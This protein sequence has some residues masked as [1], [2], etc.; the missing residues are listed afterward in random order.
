MQPTS[1]ENN[2]V[3]LHCN[4]AARTKTL[5]DKMR[6]DGAPQRV[7]KTATELTCDACE[8][9]KPHE[10][11]N[12]AYGTKLWS[13]VELC[14]MDLTVG[15]TQHSCKGL[16]GGGGGFAAGS[17]VSDGEH[18]NATA[19]ETTSL[20]ENSYPAHYPRLVA[21]RFD[22]EGCSVSR[23][24]SDTLTR[25]D[26]SPYPTAGQAHPSNLGTWERTIQ[27]LKRSAETLDEIHPQH[28]AEEVMSLV[29]SIRDELDR[30]KGYCPFQWTF[31]DSRRVWNTEATD[32]TDPLTMEHN[33]QVRT[34]A[35]KVCLVAN[36][37]ASP[38]LRQL[39]RSEGKEAVWTTL[40]RKLGWSS[41]Y[42]CTSRTER[43]EA[44]SNCLVCAQHEFVSSSTDHIRP[45]T[46]R[47]M[48]LHEVHSANLLP[49]QCEQVSQNGQVPDG[50]WTDLLNQDGPLAEAVERPQGDELENKFQEN[51][52]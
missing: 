50:V 46:T 51:Q 7:R 2:R 37:C 16:G 8:S 6:R 28:S 18:R 9:R 5:A 21:V 12:R 52:S 19:T 11:R 27:T 10:P 13:Q 26:I 25:F 15:F 24:W 42:S 47:G 40:E 41:S 17:D 43:R 38:Y 33:L 1:E 4:S 35:A 49:N 22:P 20:F 14:H 23:E 34:D 36:T 48:F 44:W 45:A 32:I 31:A 30:I 39:A 3:E 29:T